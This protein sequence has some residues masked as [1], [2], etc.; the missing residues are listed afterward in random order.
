MCIT[1]FNITWVFYLNEKRSTVALACAYSS[2][3]CADLIFYQDLFVYISNKLATKSMVDRCSHQRMQWISLIVLVAYYTV[4][5]AHFFGSNYC[6]NSNYASSL[7]GDWKFRV[8]HCKSS[9]CPLPHS[10]LNQ[11]VLFSSY[12]GEVKIG[13][14]SAEYIKSKIKFD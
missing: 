13:N 10:V 1:K 5:N 14:F 11:W 2:L 9:S 6:Q 7:V 3:Q 12:K 4:A 8:W